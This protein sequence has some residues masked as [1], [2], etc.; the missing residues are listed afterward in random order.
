MAGLCAV[1]CQRSADVVSESAT[2]A[3]TN[4]SEVVPGQAYVIDAPGHVGRAVIADDDAIW[5]VM[6]GEAGLQ[7][8]RAPSAS[9]NAALVTVFTESTFDVRPESGSARVI[10]D[11]GSHAGAERVVAIDVDGRIVPTD[12]QPT[13]RPEGEWSQT[14]R[15]GEAWWRYDEAPARMSITGSEGTRVVRLQ[16]G[17]GRL[18]E[19]VAAGDR[20]VTLDAFDRELATIDRDGVV[21]TIAVVAQGRVTSGNS[22]CV[23]GEYVMGI[24]R[25]GNERTLAVV[26]RHGGPLTVVDS[27][28]K[29]QDI[30]IMS[31]RRGR[32]IVSVGVTLH[33]VTL[34]AVRP[35]PEVWSAY[36]DPRDLGQLP[37]SAATRR[38]LTA[39]GVDSWVDLDNRRFYELADKIE[40]ADATTLTELE[41]ATELVRWHRASKERLA[42]LPIDPAY[43]ETLASLGLPRSTSEALRAA[44]HRTL[45]MLVTRT[46]AELLKTNGIGRKDIANLNKALAKRDMTLG[47]RWSDLQ[48]QASS[49]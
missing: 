43:L 18:H 38:M 47:R 40:S 25:S 8:R 6:R 13:P 31:C 15:V 28:P 10:V 35:E 49:G 5:F 24:V 41:Y 2:A 39:W 1:G 22:L 42:L 4:R 45:G 21:R 36:N 20:V 7:F 27:V 37:L 14:A 26:H 9:S 11:V 30:S 34:P 16:R 23:T 44:G 19:V 29:T 17:L 33:V 3:S 46:E 32:V 12:H 48:S